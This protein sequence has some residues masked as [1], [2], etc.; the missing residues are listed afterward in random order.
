MKSLDY[1]KSQVASMTLAIEAESKS[2]IDFPTLIDANRIASKGLF[3]KYLEG[4]RDAYLDVLN[5]SPGVP[6]VSSESPASPG[7]TAVTQAVRVAREV[8][9]L[10]PSQV[11]YEMKVTN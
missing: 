11:K 8:K 7:A 1:V 6:E 5:H 10:K 4:M 3:M 2:I 9:A